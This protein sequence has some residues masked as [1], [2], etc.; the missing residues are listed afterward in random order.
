[1]MEIEII[2]PVD[3]T[4]EN[5]ELQIDLDNKT[6]FRSKGKGLD[7]RDNMESLLKLVY[8]CGKNNEDISIIKV[9]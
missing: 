5:L 4:E 6:V 9:G 2:Y 8:L 7:I 3:P 1:M